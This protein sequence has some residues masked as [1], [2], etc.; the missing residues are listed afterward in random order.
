MIRTVCKQIVC[1]K[2]RATMMFLLAFLMAAV[3]IVDVV[4]AQRRPDIASIEQAVQV[5]HRFSVLET[6]VDHL[7]SEITG[8]R[9]QLDTQ[10][11]AEWLKLLALAGLIM[12]AGL[13]TIKKSPSKKSDLSILAPGS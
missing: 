9:L 1:P 8:L 10:F 7:A 3:A 2:F 11:K 5:E 12:E 13:R 4:K 6:K